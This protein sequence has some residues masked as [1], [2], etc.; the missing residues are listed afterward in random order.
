LLCNGCHDS[1]NMVKLEGAV[2]IE[3]SRQAIA[4]L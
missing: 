3:V 4:Y 1:G 2:A